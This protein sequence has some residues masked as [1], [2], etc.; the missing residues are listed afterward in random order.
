MSPLHLPFSPYGEG[1]AT[2]EELVF[3][4]GN[5]DERELLLS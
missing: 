5:Q 4:K 2:D 1:V 3:P